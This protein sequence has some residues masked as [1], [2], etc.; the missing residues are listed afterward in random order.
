MKNAHPTF[1][2]KDIEQLLFFGV[3][4]QVV[5][6]PFYGSCVGTL[7]SMGFTIKLA[8]VPETVDTLDK[9]VGC[10]VK[11]K[12][13]PVPKEEFRA[14]LLSSGVAVV[15][16]LSVAVNN[17]YSAWHAYFQKEISAYVDTTYSRFQWEIAAS[18]GIETIM[19][20]PLSM[21]QRLWIAF[22]SITH[23]NTERKFTI[24]V[25]ESLKPWLDIE[26][27]RAQKKNEDVKRKNVEYDTAH[28]RMI[29]GTFGMSE[30]D[31]KVFQAIEKDKQSRGEP[32]S[33]DLDI[34]T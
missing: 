9:L 5:V 4:P 10:V 31:K 29:S 7:Q 25:L 13:S 21:E 30:T 12:E 19:T 14:F 18:I 28:A 24:D 17:K 11:V 6:Y 15:D 26:L 2:H 34:I 3:P 20:P 8:P 32:A 23:K 27:Y 16:M 33:D 1:S 22:A